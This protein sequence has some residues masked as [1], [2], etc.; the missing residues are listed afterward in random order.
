MF[1]T[2]LLFSYNSAK[3]LMYVQLSILHMQRKEYHNHENRTTY[4]AMITKFSAP[5]TSIWLRK[6][7][8]NQKDIL[9][10]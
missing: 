6:R 9:V 3:I 4:A 10:P 7:T 8:N 1:I 5:L 2:K